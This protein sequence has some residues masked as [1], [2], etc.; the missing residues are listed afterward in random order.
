MAGI[1]VTI[2]N[3]HVH[4][5][6]NES[7]K[8][9]YP[10]GIHSVLAGFLGQ[11][12]EIGQVRCA[13][14]EDH[15]GALCQEVLDDTDVLVWWG[16]MAHHQVDDEVVARCA[17]RVLRGMG[18][19]VLHSGHASKLFRRL[20]GTETE[21]LRWRVADE[22]CRVWRVKGNHPIA[23]G[24][25][26]SFVVPHEEMYGEP[27]GIP[28]PDELV[29]LSWFAG[30]DVF[31]SGCTWQ[32]GEGKIF[33]FQ[34]GHE[35]YPVY[36]QPEIQRIITNAVKWAKAPNRVFNADRGGPNTAALEAL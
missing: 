10:D 1:N 22:K 30:G 29:F 9:I 35:T 23:Q 8:S 28:E 36:H 15:C 27:F 5:R 34:N 6:N 14:L 7:V 25:P 33:Y 11:D 3:E 13:T 4:E 2:F 32:R 12:A 24:I 19:V 17:Q 16:H 18:L 21:L 26:E 20:M 31:R